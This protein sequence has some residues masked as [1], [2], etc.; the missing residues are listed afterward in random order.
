MTLSDIP[1]R[2]AQPKHRILVVSPRRSGQHL[3]IDYLARGLGEATHVNNV[4][5]GAKGL[6]PRLALQ[7]RPVTPYRSGVAGAPEQQ[8]S[9]LLRPA[10]LVTHTIANVEFA[11][12]PY[13]LEAI[14]RAGRWTLV[15]LVRDPY[16]W[17]AS[18]VKV[19][20]RKAYVKDADLPHY[21]GMYKDLLALKSRS[22]L[23]VWSYN[24]FLTDPA[25]RAAKTRSFTGFDQARAEQALDE[26]PSFGGGS[27]FGG[28]DV[29]AETLRESVLERW[30]AMTGDDIYQR[31]LKDQEMLD[32]YAQTFGD[33]PDARAWADSL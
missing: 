32:A 13:D 4:L 16:N 21:I 14:H 23:D 11:E 27:S 20:R 25:Y 24:E 2:L 15:P 5:L 29:E 7:K 19:L 12:P 1:S 18:L 26:T 22:G 10:H 30:K 6:S 17:L 3:V 31:L 28:R 9:P 8:R 33:L